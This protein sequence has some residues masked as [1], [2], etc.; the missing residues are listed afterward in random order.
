MYLNGLRYLFFSSNEPNVKNNVYFDGL[1]QNGVLNEKYIN[2][3]CGSGGCERLLF[4]FCST[5]GI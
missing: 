4:F 3:V 2:I 1:E 5:Y